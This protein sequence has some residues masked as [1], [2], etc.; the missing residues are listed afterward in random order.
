MISVNDQDVYSLIPKMWL[1]F[2]IINVLPVIIAAAVT[3]ISVVALSSCLK[4]EHPI[5][6]TKIPEPANLLL[7]SNFTAWDSAHTLPLDW[8]MRQI[9]NNTNVFMPVDSAGLYMVSNSKGE[10]LL[11]QTIAVSPGTFY[12]VEAKIKYTIHNYAAGGVYAF[13]ELSG[14]LLGKYEKVKSDGEEIFAFL[15]N[16]GTAKSVNIKIGFLNGMS[17][18]FECSSIEVIQQQYVPR[19]LNRE[20]ARYLDQKMAL[21]FDATEYDNSISNLCDFVNGVLQSKIRSIDSLNVVAAAIASIIKN[22]KHYNYLPYYL[23]TLDSSFV[24]YCQ[25]SSLSLEEILENEFNIPARS[26]HLQDETG[27]GYHQ[28]LEY[29]NPFQLKWTVIDPYFSIRYQDGAGPYLS[30]DQLQDEISPWDKTTGFGQYIYSPLIQELN[31][32]W[33]LKASFVTT[34]SYLLSYP[35]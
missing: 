35:F 13:D 12:K 14:E 8:Q 22:N 15:F 29:W 17:A 27:V 2:K 3:G 20:L 34:P 31:D 6:Q 33:S 1:R 18:S 9:Y 23:E 7:N 32:I 30:G 19:V 26:I 5:V 25:R 28:F 24:G 21:S 11:F 10:H 16:S 4:T